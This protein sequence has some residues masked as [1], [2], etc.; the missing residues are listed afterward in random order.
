MASDASSP[1][2]GDDPSRSPL[3]LPEPTVAV[4]TAEEVADPPTRRV[5]PPAVRIG[6]W[7]AA[8]IAGLL[9]VLSGAAPTGTTLVDAAWCAAFAVVVTLAASRASRAT[10]LWM[11]AVAAVAAIGSI[12][13]LPAAL[14]LALSLVASVR[15]LRHRA[16]AAA[17]GALAVTALL[18][19]P[20]IGPHGVPSLIAAVAVA[21]VLWSGYTHS[22]RR[23]RRLVRRILVVAVILLALAAAMLGVATVAA[24]GGIA[25]G[26]EGA[27]AG[28]DLVRDG[29][30]AAAA[31]RFVRADRDFD[32][33][34]S[35]LGG[36][37]TRP[38]R[39]VPVLAQHVEA[40]STAADEGG[41]LVS[42]AA[43]AAST[44]PYQDLKAS[45]G[46]VDL[47]QVERM[48]EPVADLDEALQQ[49]GAAVADAQSPWLVRPVADGLADLEEE[50]GS[51]APEAAL[52]DDAL[53][54]APGLLGADGP[55]RYLVLFTSPAESRFLGGF[56]ASYGVLSAV[57]GK[58]DLVVDGKVSDLAASS[59]YRDRSIEGQDEFVTRYG[60]LSPERYFQNLTASPDMA[61]TAEVSASLFEQTTGTS[62]DGVVV[63]DPFGL[64]ALLELTGPIEIPDRAAP[65]TSSNT[66]R[67]LLLDQYL[68][69][70]DRAERKER[71][72]DV[73]RETFDALTSRELPGP[74]TLG[75]VLGPVVDEKR[76]MFHP[77][78]D[79]E[80]ALMEDLGVDGTFARSEGA[81]LLSFR[82]SNAEANK[83][84]TFL[85]RTVT[86][87]ATYDADTGGVRA[88]ATV[89]LT[90]RAPATGLP[91]YVAGTGEDIPRGT[92][93]LYTS[94]YSPLQV[95]AATL[96]GE[97]LGLEA[98]DELGVTA[99]STLVEIPP[100][101][102]I[103]L[104]Y[105]L[106]GEIGEGGYQLDS[107]PQPA[108]GWSDEVIHVRGAAGAPPVSD[109]PTGRVSREVAIFERPWRAD[110]EHAVD[111]AE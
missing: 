8:G 78:E 27:R 2:G 18:R 76:L 70:D 85:D 69:E 20:D 13:L 24:G 57:D 34:S 87:D 73:G 14:A 40:M 22:P 96:D 54:V 12:A 72:E 67:Y 68:E 47:V 3:L 82:T 106:A 4:R 29:E 103:T 61:T 35:A 97:E 98:Q 1:P 111:L 102:S 101:G 86:Y 100:R 63:V 52:A 44:A 92:T 95:V 19:L 75:D 6:V 66:A 90:N 36:I 93:R 45:D 79:D 64:A 62:V 9:A 65:L 107:L 88:T 56:T 21:P 80:L 99:Y 23:V 109:A 48:Q 55:R 50:I 53:Q 108:A 81:D 59:D 33:A 28:A 74:R 77:F 94:L 17:G 49:A 41:R 91:D 89:V 32:S 31:D 60:R 104:V 38:A 71:L 58:V 30:H 83:L 42:A 16:L 110:A 43:D 105:E 26:V 39:A 7:A 25:D 51:I 37:L 10:G 46:Q 84:D 5:S 15:E 11:A